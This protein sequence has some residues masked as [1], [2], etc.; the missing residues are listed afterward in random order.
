MLLAAVT[1]AALAGWCLS[2]G[3]LRR[4]RR[5]TGQGATTS[6]TPESRRAMSLAQPARLGRRW[7][8]PRAARRRR[9]E[10]VELCQALSAELQAGAPARVALA[11]AAEGVP[12]FEQIAVV[13]RS[14]YGDVS[15]V[16]TVLAR[17]PGCE[18]L[19]GLAACWRLCERSGVGLA[20]ATARLADALRDDEQIRR[21]TAAQVAGPRA[22]CVLLAVLPLFG[23]AMGGAL[24][25]EPLHLLFGTPVGVGLLTSAAVLETAGLVWMTRITGG[26]L[27]R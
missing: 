5:V 12:A 27:P 23:L 19:A 10:V 3:E 18:G 25:A 20:Q 14:T 4:L 24:G 6:T 15:S 7:L 11:A 13:A 17:V 9:T 1:L 21:E 2:G 16:L 22:T 26:V 8:R